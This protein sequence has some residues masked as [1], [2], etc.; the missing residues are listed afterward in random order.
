MSPTSAK[1]GDLHYTRLKTDQRE[2][3]MDQKG[4]EIVF[5]CNKN[6]FFS[7]NFVCGKHL[8]QKF[9]K[10]VTGVVKKKTLLR[11]ISTLLPNPLLSSTQYTHHSMLD[12]L[13]AVL[14]IPLDH[15]MWSMRS[16][17]HLNCRLHGEQ[18]S[19]PPV[20]PQPGGFYTEV[21]FVSAVS[22]GSSVKFLPAV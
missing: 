14:V 19:P 7:G 22:A 8:S 3:K 1:N 16:S 20:Q 6:T 18:C 11:I 12:A 4:L 15:L 2:P 13:G 5:L 21:K 17:A 10:N 9:A